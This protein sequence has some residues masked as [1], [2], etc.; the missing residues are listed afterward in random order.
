MLFESIL[1][2]EQKII[3]SKLY[4]EQSTQE[5]EMEKNEA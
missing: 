5:F 1:I 4:I 2:Q 3:L